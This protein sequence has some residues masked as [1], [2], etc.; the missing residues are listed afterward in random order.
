MN[1]RIFIYACVT[2]LVLF[3]T[4]CYHLGTPGG[5][6]YQLDELHI[7]N[8]TTEPLVGPMMRSSVRELFCTDPAT[9]LQDKDGKAAYDIAIKVKEIKNISLAR[10]KVRDRKSRDDEEDA[11]QTVLFRITLVADVTITKK[12]DKKPILQRTYHGH[13][14]LPQ[15]HDRQ[16]T[17]KNACKQATNHLARQFVDDLTTIVP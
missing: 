15:M 8:T 7:N 5:E 17:L 2:S 12:G 14:D 10:A 6:K 3:T 16:V 11:Y 9:T 1:V 4:G 13:G